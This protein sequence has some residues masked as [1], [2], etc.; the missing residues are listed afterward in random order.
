MNVYD[1]ARSIKTMGTTTTVW[2]DPNKISKRVKNQV[3]KSVE[4][5]Y[6]S[7]GYRSHTK[8]ILDILEKKN[9]GV[10]VQFSYYGPHMPK[11]MPD[12]M[13][14]ELIELITADIAAYKVSGA[15]NYD[16]KHE[17]AKQTLQALESGTP[18]DAP[19]RSFCCIDKEFRRAGGKVIAAYESDE[20]KQRRKE[21]VDWLQNGEPIQ[22]HVY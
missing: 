19:A 8:N 6:T 16:W 10:V 3:I 20:I 4:A 15:N 18:H 2:L 5:G 9:P 1:I 14:A 22:I 7:F 21:I 11:S 13:R 12:A 17:Y